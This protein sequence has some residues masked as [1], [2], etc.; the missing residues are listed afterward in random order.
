MNY[1]KGLCV[2]IFS[3]TAGFVFAQKGHDMKF[4]IHNFKGKKALIAYHFADKQYIMDTLD[5]NSAGY[6]EMK[7]DTTMRGGL[8]L[9]VLP[10]KNNYFEFIVDN[11]DTQFFTLETDSADLI[12]KMKVTGSKQ[13]EIFF[14]DISFIS[15]KR[16]IV[17]D[18]QKKIKESG[19]DSVKI[20]KYQA[21]L[22]DI[23]K[24]VVTARE[25][26]MKDN[27]KM[28]Y[29]AML[30]AT[31]N[32]EIPDT[33]KDESGKPLDSLFAYKYYK[34]HFWDFI[35]FN[36]DRLL[37]TPILLGKI[38]EYLDKVCSQA[39]DSLV[40]ET[41]WLISRTRGNKEILK[42]MVVTCLNKYASDKIM[43][44]DAVYVSI[45]E[46][47]YCT[48]IARAWTDSAQCVKICDRVQKLM[49]TILERRA[50]ELR[51]MDEYDK[52]VSLS[53]VEADYTILYFWDYDCGHCKKVT[54][55]VVQVVNAYLQKG[56]NIKLYTVQINGTREDW[57]K[58]LKDYNLTGKGIINT[59]DPSR[60]TG[61]DKKYD[62]LS[63]PRIVVLD[64]DKKIKAKYISSKQLDEILNYFLYGKNEPMVLF[65]EDAPEHKDGEGK[66]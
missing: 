12:N 20:K 49:P 6:F 4:K 13:N 31:K 17:D 27:P 8:Y 61:F 33:P 7:A 65:D 47:Y 58:K 37:L 40:K 54:P 59:A 35:D 43:G 36:D 32:P 41:E 21:E 64:K 55:R 24:Q 11:K 2:L 5:I 38:N 63:T 10:P 60:I 42:F 16:K 26:I 23:D 29:T 15:E 30:K 51:I 56:A 50:P 57:K 18:L 34:S 46:N 66:H 48:G 52:W 9:F 44:H 53:E 62:L 1:L 14:N 3:L 28:L 22:K 45:G 19:T 25:K 39:N